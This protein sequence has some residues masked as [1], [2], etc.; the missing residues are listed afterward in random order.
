MHSPK[1][2]TAPRW[3]TQLTTPLD[4]AL[5]L[6]PGEKNVWQE[7]QTARKSTAAGVILS[8]SIAVACNGYYDS[9]G[10]VSRATKAILGRHCRHSSASGGNRL[11][12][13][14]SL[15]SNI[16]QLRQKPSVELPRI[17]W[18]R[19]ERGETAQFP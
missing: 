1:S 14:L 3:A 19:I 11:P 8:T 7:G 17:T 10:Q 12:A 16:A 6:S 18:G 5:D 2:G 9:V 13:G 15:P 4:R